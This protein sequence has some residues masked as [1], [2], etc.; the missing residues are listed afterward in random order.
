MAVTPNF[1]IQDW[2]DVQSA[3]KN[4]KPQQLLLCRKNRSKMAQEETV[5]ANATGNV[6]L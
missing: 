4:T 2:S 6:S 5:F 3:G 1:G